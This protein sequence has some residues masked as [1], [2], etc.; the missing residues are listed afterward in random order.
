MESLKSRVLILGLDKSVVMLR[1]EGDSHDYCLMT[2]R[3]VEGTVKWVIGRVVCWI[4]YAK[5]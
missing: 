3:A 2:V 4:N 5:N 1:R